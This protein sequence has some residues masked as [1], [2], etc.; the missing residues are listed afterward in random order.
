M[1]ILQI[2]IGPDST[3]LA[4]VAVWCSADTFALKKTWFYKSIIQLQFAVFD[5]IKK[6]GN[7]YLNAKQHI[8]RTA[9]TKKIPSCKSAT[10]DHK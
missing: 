6:S 4:K 2:E 1:C 7:R 8:Q 10:E 5:I 3:D 9:V